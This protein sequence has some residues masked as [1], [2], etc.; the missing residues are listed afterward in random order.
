MKTVNILLLIIILFGLGGCK[1]GPT[2]YEI[3]EKS[4]NYEI[5]SSYYPTYLKKMREIYSEDKYIY[6]LYVSQ[7]P[8]ECVY[9]Y[10]TNRD[11]K[12]EKVIGWVI[13]SGEKNCK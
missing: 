8:E 10:F 1:V 7:I 6:V 3:F 4:M 12:P 9:G 2:N 13:L 11:N 5:D